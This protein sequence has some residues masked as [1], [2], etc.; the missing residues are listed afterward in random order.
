MT[1]VQVGYITQ[2][3]SLGDLHSLGPAA[4]GPRCVNHIETSTY[5]KR[6]T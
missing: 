2:C 4:L 6:V 1:T 3:H 5:T